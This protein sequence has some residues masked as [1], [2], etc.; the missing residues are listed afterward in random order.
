MHVPTLHI[1]DSYGKVP[2]ICHHRHAAS[3]RHTQGH[4]RRRLLC[5]LPGLCQSLSAGRHFSRKTNGAGGEKMVC[6]FRQMHS[7]FR[8]SI[9]LRYLHHQMPVVG[10]GA[11]AKTHAEDVGQ[12]GNVKITTMTPPSPD[13]PVMPGDERPGRAGNITGPRTPLSPATISKRRRLIGAFFHL[14]GESA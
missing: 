14:A 1:P 12:T 7:L 2:V 8:R 10:T 4:R 5:K 3:R 6:R 9:R 11:G 13:I